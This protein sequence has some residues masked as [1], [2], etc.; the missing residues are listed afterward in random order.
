M[1][2]FFNEI[3]NEILDKRRK[4]IKQSIR[5]DHASRDGILQ[6]QE[7][8]L[9]SLLNQFKSINTFAQNILQCSSPQDIIDFEHQIT[10]QCEKLKGDKS[11]AILTPQA[12][13]QKLV[14]FK[15]EEK[16]MEPF[17]HIASGI[18]IKKCKINGLESPSII[19]GE[20][21]TFHVILYPLYDH[22]M[23]DLKC[24][25]VQVQYFNSDDEVTTEKVAI[26]RDNIS[27]QSEIDRLEITYI[28]T[29]SGNHM[30]SV[31]VEGQHIPRSPF[32]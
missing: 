23:L 4:E 10:M 5:D 8:S 25:T 12:Q 30:V 32:Q 15:R 13:E 24:L 22:Y 21:I 14:K 29:K 19:V 9:D 17:S 7:D 2:N 31:L 28:A 18:D 26:K 16:I 27:D 3:E 6:S 20:K 11:K 1:D